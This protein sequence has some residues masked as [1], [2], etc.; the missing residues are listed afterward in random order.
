MRTLV[1]L[2]AALL[3]A[4]CGGK[5]DDD[6]ATPT[7]KPTSPDKG[8]GSG[9]AMATGSGSAAGSGSATVADPAKPAG[10][11]AMIPVTSKSP[12]AIK[13]FEQGRE[14]S[15]GDR[16]S[17][18]IE[19]F[20]KA[21]GLDAD[22]AQAHAYLGIVTPGPPGMAELDKAKT[23]AAKLPEPERLFIEGAHANRSGDHAAMIAAYTKVADLAPGDWRILIAL[24]NDANDTGDN[25]KAIKLFEKA[26]VV[27]PDLALAQDGLAYGHAGLRELDAALA[28]AK[29]QVELL[30]KQPSPQDTLGEV[31]LLAGKYDDAEKAFQ[32]AITIEPKYIAAWQGIELARAYR[33]DWKGAFAAN[34]S[35]N[36]GAVDTYNSVEVIKDGAWLA[37]AAGNLPDAI[38]RL[39]VIEADVE[40]KKT[41]AYAFAAL[42]RA[43]MLQL[44][45]KYP[46]AAKW[47]DTGNKRREGLP[48]F[49]RRLIAQT[50]AI[51]VLRNAA[52]TAT[53]A[54]DAD[55]LIGGLDKDAAASGDPLSKS[56][57]A[58]GH[59]LAAWAKT[60]AK[61]AVTELAKCRVQLLACRYDLAAAQRK[62][63]DAAGADATEKQIR[64]APQREASAVY[65]VGQ[66]PKK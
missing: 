42:D 66:F 31:L 43:M 2:A 57:A 34:E 65:F 35:R 23:L 4:S 38:A 17:E 11:T 61:D 37:F 27:K 16:G 8:T 60:G 45:E 20:K 13:A 7:A 39:D 55:K 30:P 40:A 64:E 3:A 22:F 62:A 49:T 48:G 28:A 15:D 52:M 63:G 19:P 6:K 46:D 41:P 12:D 53:A 54:P 58:W 10:G 56:F 36:T 1:Y 51:G 5:K 9:A 26:L 29:K 25:A 50:H 47:L 14:L 24:G 59:G 44:S 18:A 33:G 32:A 21:I